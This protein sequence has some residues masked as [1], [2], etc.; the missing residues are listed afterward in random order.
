MTSKTQVKSRS[1]PSHSKIRF[2]NHPPPLKQYRR[3]RNN[4]SSF[5]N[6]LCLSPNSQTKS[7]TYH[8]SKLTIHLKLLFLKTL[9]SRI[10]EHRTTRCV[11]TQSSKTTKIS[12]LSSQ[13]PQW[14]PR[15]ELSFKNSKTQSSRYNS[16]R[17][18]SSQ[19]FWSKSYP[20]NSG[21]LECPL[22][23]VSERM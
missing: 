18:I 16:L 3:I 8:F 12:K 10:L 9:S 17:I 4:K 19:I 13:F 7:A 6:C 15:K 5:N 21:K 20:N 23:Q 1:G 14:V 2:K 11:P 22:L